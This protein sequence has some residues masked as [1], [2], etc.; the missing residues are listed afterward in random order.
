MASPN[1]AAIKVQGCAVFVLWTVVKKTAGHLGR[2]D[3]SVQRP[4]TPWGSGGGL[5]I[6]KAMTH[7]F[8]PNYRIMSVG[9]V[10]FVYKGNLLLAAH[11]T[12]HLTDVCPLC[13]DLLFEVDSNV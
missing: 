8:S 1:G 3:R 7:D 6:I 12:L 5:C 4:H 13:K 2:P 9:H 11:I 10:D